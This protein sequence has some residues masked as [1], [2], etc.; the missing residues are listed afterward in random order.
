ML[1]SKEVY[2]KMNTENVY[3]IRI[4]STDENKDKGFSILMT[5]GT[6]V[7]CLEDEKYVVSE[8][9]LKK[10]GDNGV[11]FDFVDNAPENTY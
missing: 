11:R 4:N 10:L 6:S 8:R 3:Q 2:K 7:I 5:S 1:R 9:L